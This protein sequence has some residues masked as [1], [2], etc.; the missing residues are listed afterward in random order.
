MR[1]AG[2]LLLAVRAWSQDGEAVNR[3]MCAT[4]HP[5]GR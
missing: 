4:C 3:Q 1:V 5:A 2:V